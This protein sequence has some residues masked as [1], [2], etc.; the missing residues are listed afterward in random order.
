V[1]ADGTVTADAPDPL[2]ALAHC[3]RVR[4]GTTATDADKA[5]LVEHFSRLNG[6]ADAVV[7][8]MWA[9][10]RAAPAPTVTEFLAREPKGPA[11]V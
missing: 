6:K 4:A 3:I 11:H 9:Y 10:W 2:A 1:T 7:Q 8:R 5:A